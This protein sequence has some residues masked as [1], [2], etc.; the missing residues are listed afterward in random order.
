MKDMTTDAPQWADELTRELKQL[1]K[2]MRLQLNA[3]RFGNLGPDRVLTVNHLGEPFDLHLP[4]GDTDYIQ[5][6]ILN[7]RTFYEANLLENLRQLKVVKPGGVIID[8]GSNI[9]NHAVFFAAYLSPA[10]LYAF[11]PQ[12]I[13]HATL[14]RNIELNHPDADIRCVR[15]LLG[16]QSGMGDV[17]SYKPGNQGGASFEASEGGSTPMLSLDD[18]MEDGD[19]A[20]VSFIKIDVEGYQA[21]VLRGADRI[22]RE[23]Q[24]PLW[25]EVFQNEKA[26]TDEVLRPYGYKAAKL[27]NN[28]YIYQI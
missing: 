22:L 6:K 17:A 27:S 21:E 13:A 23:S 20:R 3:T 16:S 19:H 2:F 12:Q 14:T 18:A 10:R 1:N 11:E 15:S 8:A 5:R 4:F 7:D 28:N 26:E 25:V 24:P 9:G